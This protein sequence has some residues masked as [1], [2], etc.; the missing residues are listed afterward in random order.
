MV[1][2]AIF[3]RKDAHLQVIEER[4]TLRTFRKSITLH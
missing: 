3:F 4:N 1:W 2:G